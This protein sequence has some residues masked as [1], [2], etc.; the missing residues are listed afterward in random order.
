[1]SGALIIL[2][3]LLGAGAGT[4]HFVALFRDAELLVR[5]G[6]P[7]AAMALRL[8]RVLLSIAVLIA[9]ARQ[10]WP[11]LLGAATGFMV[12]RQVVMRRLG[13]IA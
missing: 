10:G 12:A 4:V 2:F 3:L 8:G 11:M 1:V 9:A 5:G 6:S 13:A 7:L